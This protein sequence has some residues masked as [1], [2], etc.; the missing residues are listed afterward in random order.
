MRDREFC[1]RLQQIRQKYG[2]SNP[3]PPAFRH[4]PSMH[5]PLA[6]YTLP[7]GSLTLRLETP[8]RTTER[9]ATA[10]HRSALSPPEVSRTP[11]ASSNRSPSR[12]SRIPLGGH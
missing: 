7:Y 5:A 6:P 12:Q 2:Y 3:V 9:T 4:P 10:R 11:F 8:A 1:L